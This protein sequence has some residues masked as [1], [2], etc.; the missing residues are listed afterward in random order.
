VESYNELD[1]M[2]T[3]GL[4]SSKHKFS[5]YQALNNALQRIKD[6]GLIDSRVDTSGGY[7]YYVLT[8]LG[9]N[10]FSRWFIHY[11][12]DKMIPNELLPYFLEFTGKFIEDNMQIK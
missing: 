6:I 2:R 3:Y 1:R 11:F 9:M 7:N 8:Q 4:L 5:S 10:A 12:I